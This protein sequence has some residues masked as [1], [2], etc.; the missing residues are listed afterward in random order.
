MN[1]TYDSHFDF[2]AAKEAYNMC[3]LYATAYNETLL[4]R[5]EVEKPE[6]YEE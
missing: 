3:L 2:K 6:F 5:M 1:D 4:K